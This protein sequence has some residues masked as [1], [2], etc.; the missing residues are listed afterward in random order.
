MEVACTEECV[1]ASGKADALDRAAAEAI[2]GFD[3]FFSV[4]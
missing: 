1:E 3:I 2:G 4:A